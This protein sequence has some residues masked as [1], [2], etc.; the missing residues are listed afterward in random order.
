MS[1]DSSASGRVQSMLMP[2]GDRWENRW[3][4]EGEHTYLVIRVPEGGVD[5]F[6]DEVCACHPTVWQ[7]DHDA[8]RRLTDFESPST[9]R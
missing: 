9:T 8:D 2:Y 3:V 4:E 7:V 5:G 1:T 6:I